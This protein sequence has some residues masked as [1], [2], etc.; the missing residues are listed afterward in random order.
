MGV[1]LPF[2]QKNGV[3]RNK[4]NYFRSFSRTLLAWHPLPYSCSRRWLALE[5][6]PSVPAVTLDNASVWSYIR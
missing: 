5:T 2:G 3:M 4:N 1:L 6:W